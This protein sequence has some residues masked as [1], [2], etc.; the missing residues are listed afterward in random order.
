[1]RSPYDSVEQCMGRYFARGVYSL[2][3]CVRGRSLP[4][5]NPKSSLFLSFAQAEDWR[6]REIIPAV[7]RVPRQK[8][9]FVYLDEESCRRF[10]PS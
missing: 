5:K 10:Q 2:Y 9:K 8:R 1:M 4:R 3:K 6:V 7:I